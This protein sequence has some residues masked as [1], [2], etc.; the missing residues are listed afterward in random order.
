M[1]IQV[2]ENRLALYEETGGLMGEVLFPEEGGCLVITHTFVDEKYRGQGLAGQLLDA[3]VAE[4]RKRKKKA[5]PQCSYSVAYF[6]KHPESQ[7]VVLR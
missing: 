3:L 4:L 5:F 1:K 6:A 2:E 7:D